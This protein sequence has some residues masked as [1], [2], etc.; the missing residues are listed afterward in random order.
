MGRA[1]SS[2]A[3]RCMTE[4]KKVSSCTMTCSPAAPCCPSSNACSCDRQDSSAGRYES[5]KTLPAAA[6]RLVTRSAAS[7]S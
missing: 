4:S 5:A 1:S 2:E 3:P 6:A 7:R